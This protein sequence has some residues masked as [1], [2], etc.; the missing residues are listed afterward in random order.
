MSHGLV[1]MNKKIKC[2]TCGKTIV[3]NPNKH[4]YRPKYCPH[5]RAIYK[6]DSLIHIPNLDWLR[7]ILERRHHRLNEKIFKYK[8]RAKMLLITEAQNKGD[9]NYEPSESEI[10]KRVN[11]MIATD[12]KFKEL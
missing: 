12:K 10:N 9:F 6:K 4:R 8:G 2:E 11:E 7:N 1:Y 5:C 3:D